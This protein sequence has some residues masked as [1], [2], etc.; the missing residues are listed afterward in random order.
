MSEAV[1]EVLHESGFKNIRMMEFRDVEH[2]EELT[3][4]FMKKL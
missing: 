3:K 2:G 4:S 1:L